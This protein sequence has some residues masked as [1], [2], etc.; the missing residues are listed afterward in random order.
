MNLPDNFIPT[1][2]IL[3]DKLEQ[4][5]VELHHLK[6]ANTKMKKEIRA[7]NRVISKLKEREAKKQHYKNG[8][9]G[10]NFNG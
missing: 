4:L 6:R 8:R 10:T 2:T 3:L 7:K 1:E 5:N 9:R